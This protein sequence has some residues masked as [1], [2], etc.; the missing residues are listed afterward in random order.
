MIHVSVR[1]GRT[2]TPGRNI[3]ARVI[4]ETPLSKRPVQKEEKI[5]LTAFCLATVLY[6]LAWWLL[7]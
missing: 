2:M 7:I 5:H 1:E 6:G 3:V 4:P